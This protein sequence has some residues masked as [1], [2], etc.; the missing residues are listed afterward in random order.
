MFLTSWNPSGV[1][2]AQA[3]AVAQEVDLVFAKARNFS[4]QKGF[5]P[6]TDYAGLCKI[7]LEIVGKERPRKSD[8]AMSQ[9]DFIAYGAY[10]KSLSRAQL[11]GQCLESVQRFKMARSRSGPDWRGP[12]IKTAG[13]CARA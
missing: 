3:D 4:A 8:I 1:T 6:P 2:Y 11:S 7:F 5:C 13:N 9:V 12:V 10:E